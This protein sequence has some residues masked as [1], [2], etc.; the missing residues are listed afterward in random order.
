MAPSV[1]RPNIP[2]DLAPHEAIDLTT[3]IALA[4]V[5][6]IVQTAFHCR[7]RDFLVALKKRNKSTRLT[8][9]Y[10]SYIEC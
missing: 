3:A 10:I 9:G 5:S 7:Y 2:F 6:L 1:Y 8:I 4:V